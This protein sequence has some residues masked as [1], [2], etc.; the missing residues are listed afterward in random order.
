GTWLASQNRGDFK[1]LVEVDTGLLNLYGVIQVDPKRHHHVKVEA[2]QKLID[3][4]VSPTGQNAIAAF[5][6]NGE[7]LFRPNAK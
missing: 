7:Q 1:A 4:L 5:K 2:A 3:W 6:I